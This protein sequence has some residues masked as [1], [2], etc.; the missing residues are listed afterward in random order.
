MP[1]KARKLTFYVYFCNLFIL[2]QN[3]VL[4]LLI[5][6]CVAQ[7]EITS[8]V[9]WTENC[10]WL[11]FFY[12]FFYLIKILV[13]Y[14]WFLPV[15]LILSTSNTVNNIHQTTFVIQFLSWVSYLTALFWEN[16][17]LFFIF[18]WTFS[19]FHPG[20]TY[21]ILVNFKKNSINK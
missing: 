19:A 16:L 18:F 12:F 10:A 17:D 6:D 2:F 7:E 11:V 5:F 1:T 21:F 3:E 9:K 8:V 13:S 20:P 15:K 14:D 4:L